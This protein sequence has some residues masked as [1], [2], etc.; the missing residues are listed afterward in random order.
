MQQNDAASMEMYKGVSESV[1]E[2]GGRESRQA[3]RQ[4]DRQTDRNGDR[5][6]VN[7]GVA[8]DLP[9][10]DSTSCVLVNYAGESFQCFKCI[11]PRVFRNFGPAG[12]SN[13][14]PS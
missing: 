11:Q 3:D 1:R 7:V 2:G 9:S 10:F 6:C 8:E 14:R 13:K 5:E 12:K 4:T